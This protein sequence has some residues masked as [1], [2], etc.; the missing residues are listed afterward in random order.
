MHA[1]LARAF[2]LAVLLLSPLRSADVAASAVPP[3]A[4]GPSRGT[5]LL[6]GG[7]SGR[8]A[9]LIEMF[10]NRAGGPDANF[11]IV[12][13]GAG[14][15]ATD[16][17]EKIYR[18][19]EVLAVWRQRGLKHVRMLH[20]ADR[21]V[22]NTEAFVQPLREA[23]AVWFE[24]DRPLDLLESYADTLTHRE[25][26]QVLHRGG[27]LAGNSAGAVVLGEHVLRPDLAGAPS[28][29]ATPLRGFGFFR[30][31]VL[32]LQVNTRHRWSDLAPVIRTRPD[33]IGFGLSETTALLVTGDRCEIIGKWN[34]A[35]HDA[36][37]VPHPGEAA[38]R[39]L[40]P[41][42]AFN[43]QTRRVERLGRGTLAPPPLTPANGPPPA[44]EAPPAL[45]L[46][47]GPAKGT[48][49]IVGGGSPRGTGIM[50]TFVNRA[51]GLDARIVVV[52]TA[53]GNR[54]PNGEL[55]VYKEDDVL[56]AWKRQLG[57]K[58]VRMLHTADRAVANSEEFVQPLREADGVWFDG[59]R[60]W[61]LVDSYLGTL[62]QREFEKVLERG[63]VIGGTSSGATIQGEYLVRGAIAGPEI[64]MPP[65]PEHQRGF[66]FLRHTAID[67]HINTRDR[68]DDLGQVIKQFPDLLGL[69]LSEGTAIVVNGNR[70]EVVGKWKVTVYD[71]LRP[72]QPWEKPYSVLSA[73]DVFDM[74][75]RRVVR[76]GEA[77][78]GI[79]ALLGVTP[80]RAP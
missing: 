68:W 17:R 65:E 74:A 9:G 1:H 10:I 42:D 61:H 6:I 22:A 26:E 69:G 80:A 50:E 21:A 12:P 72:W 60:H 44:P 43:L 79:P 34:V 7:G 75:T 58:N 56:A 40:Q 32:D 8:G 78:Q 29:S 37:W 3:P 4:Y 30:H 62:A 20:T 51:G 16:G 57:M 31:A 36:T 47:Y 23:S 71:G 28:T 54:R 55:I 19:D 67:Q 77:P 73:G 5:L 15:L 45:P 59:G 66:A 27:I 13:T 25:L 18:E 33:L 11:V 76:V 48:L 2:L 35:V 52:P 38:F 14:R 24:G 64:V 41:G 39:L 49:V 53:G 46:D 63:G 70:F